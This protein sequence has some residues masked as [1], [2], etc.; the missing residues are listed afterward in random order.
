MDVK[1]F[2]PL[3]LQIVLPE[4][5]D[6]PQSLNDGGKMFDDVI[7]LL[8]GIINGKAETDG[9]MGSCERDTHGPEN[10]RRFEGARR[11]GRP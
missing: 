9:T 10:V 8:L 6:V 4:R 11:T 7:H 1:L 3:G 5:R 2:L